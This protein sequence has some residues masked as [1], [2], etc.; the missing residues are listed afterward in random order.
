MNLGAAIAGGNGTRREGDFYP[1]PL[2]CTNTLLANEAEHIR[3]H[4]MTVSEPACG[5]G[6]LA[7]VLE[8]WGF[9]VDASDLHD[10]G[11]GRS[12][13]DF[14]RTAPGPVVVT[15]PPFDCADAL[16][17]MGEMF[18]VRY[19]ALLLKA[20]FWNAKKRKAQFDRWKPAA[21]YPLTW[22]VDFT[23]QGRPTMDVQ[24]VVW[25]ANRYGAAKFQPLARVDA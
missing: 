7:R 23:G 2:E 17:A 4:G 11:Y 24:W 5:D 10:R 18:D 20:T 15:N 13:V 12:G 9:V 6:A 8:K 25:D 3:R 1:T 16:I 19:M 21:L 14:T 22:R